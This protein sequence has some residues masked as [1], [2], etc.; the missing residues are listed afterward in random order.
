VERSLEESTEQEVLRFRPQRY[1]YDED[2]GSAGL[3]RRPLNS[4]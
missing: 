3:H 2:K 1:F 4:R